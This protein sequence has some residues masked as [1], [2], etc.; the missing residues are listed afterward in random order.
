MLGEG[1][2]SKIQLGGHFEEQL[3]S[4]VSRESKKSE[5]VKDSSQT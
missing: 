1:D 4:A 3:K 5:G 2:G